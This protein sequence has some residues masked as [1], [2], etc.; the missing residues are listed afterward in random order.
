MSG[1]C[2]LSGMIASFFAALL[3]SVI[4]SGPSARI[5]S[6]VGKMNAKH[7]ARI[8]ANSSIAVHAPNSPTPLFKGNEDQGYAGC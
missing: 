5:R 1:K 6:E 4:V 2:G 7:G 3:L 8:Q